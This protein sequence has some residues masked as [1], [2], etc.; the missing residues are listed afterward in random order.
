MRYIVHNVTTGKRSEVSA[1]D[2]PHAAELIAAYYN[3]KGGEVI[4]VR[5][6]ETGKWHRF[7]VWPI[8]RYEARYRGDGHDPMEKR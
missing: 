6:A 3:A 5:C 4:A 1:T 2:S 7:S 8:T